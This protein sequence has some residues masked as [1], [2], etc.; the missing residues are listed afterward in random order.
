MGVSGDRADSWQL[1]GTTRCRQ[2]HCGGEHE[3]AQATIGRV[4]A[5]ASFSRGDADAAAAAAVAATG[6]PPAPPTTE[7]VAQH[8]R[9]LEAGM[10]R[11]RFTFKKSGAD[12]ANGAALH[13]ETSS[14]VERLPRATD[15]TAAMTRSFTTASMGHEEPADVAAAMA[16]GP[17]LQDGSVVAAGSVPD[18]GM[19]PPAATP[20]NKAPNSKSKRGRFNVTKSVNGDRGEHLAESADMDAAARAACADACL[21]PPLPAA[22]EPLLSQPQGDG[23]APAAAP[24]E[25]PQPPAAEPGAGTPAGTAAI[26]T[27][28]ASGTPAAA[29]AK[30]ASRFNVVEERGDWPRRAAGG[31]SVAATPVSSHS[32]GAAARP[33]VPPP[34]MMA[35]V[36]KKLKELVD[37]SNAQQE[38]MRMLMSAIGES[39]RGKDK[40]LADL[41]KNPLIAVHLMGSEASSNQLVEENARLAAEVEEYKRKHKAAAEK[42]RAVTA[43]LS[44]S[45]TAVRDV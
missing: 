5:N 19:L 37:A 38:A 11:G 16:L 34:D 41:G 39:S 40:I 33:P 28:A 26:A 29:N 10:Q 36:N 42:V 22:R 32:G 27:A 44:V 8:T 23:A 20:A 43:Q 12:G 14:A 17:S 6:G 45:A 7:N 3:L 15:E 35:V 18:D 21:S 25:P 13:S 4:V 2:E 9:A 30:K 24:V 1:C 31:E